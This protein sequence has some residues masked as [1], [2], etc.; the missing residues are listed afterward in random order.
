MLPRALELHGSARFATDCTGAR[1]HIHSPAWE[2]HKAAHPNEV[3]GST[4][5]QICGLGYCGLRFIEEDDPTLLPG[6]YNLRYKV[7]NKRAADWLFPEPR[8]FNA[9]MQFGT[10]REDDTLRL[11]DRGN[12]V[13]DWNSSNYLMLNAQWPGCHVTPDALGWYDHGKLWQPAVFEVKTCRY[14]REDK[15]LQSPHAVVPYYYLM[16]PVM[17][18]ALMEFETAVFF[19]SDP[20]ARIVKGVVLTELAPTIEWMRARI[21]VFHRIVNDPLSSTAQKQ[22][23]MLM[24]LPD[25]LRS[26]EKL[27]A[28][29]FYIEILRERMPVPH[30]RLLEIP[31]AAGDAK[32]Y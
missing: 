29:D 15:F 25:T 3:S 2:A 31:A 4:V 11:L 14:G 8:E 30:M 16:Q 9:R 5:S 6:E 26:E 32:K 23:E 22:R 24:H 12:C 13:L 17:Q 10:E 1:I 7:T 27:N 18:A 20:D 19:K 21:A 28:G